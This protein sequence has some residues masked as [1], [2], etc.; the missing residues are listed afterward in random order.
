MLPESNTFFLIS[1]S[2]IFLF[3]HIF[4]SPSPSLPLPPLPPSPTVIPR[5]GYPNG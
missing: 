4:T 5:E 1:S 2:L 3:H